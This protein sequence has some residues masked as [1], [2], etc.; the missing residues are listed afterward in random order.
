MGTN[1]A[2]AGDEPLGSQV[3][4]VGE[5]TLTL[6]VE[7]WRETG[8]AVETR[9]VRIRCASGDVTHGVWAG[10]PVLDLADAAGIHPEATHLQAA[11]VDG[12]CA[13]IELADLLDGLVAFERVD[14]G[15]DAMPRVVSPAVEAT[16]S[17]QEV[18]TLVGIALGPGQDRERWETITTKSSEES[19]DERAT[20]R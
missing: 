17:V 8:F 11:S 6:P 5:E 16:R 20:S 14:T 12:F 15:S 18:R 9:E 7:G 13:C 2:D 1:T 19:P 10:I 4:V 3:A